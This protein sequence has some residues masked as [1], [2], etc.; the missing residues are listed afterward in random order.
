MKPCI[1]KLSTLTHILC[2]MCLALWSN[3]C[4]TSTRCV[5]AEGTSATVQNRLER[6]DSTYQRDSVYIR[7]YIRGDTVYCTHWRDR[8]RERVVIHTDTLYCDREVVQQLPPERYVP[9]AVKWLAWVGVSAIG[10]AVLYVG[11]RWYMGRR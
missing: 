3:A 9:Q 8:W 2:M 6:R 5:A 7:E 10:W 4:A 1:S 11:R